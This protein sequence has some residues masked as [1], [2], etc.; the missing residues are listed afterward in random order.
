[1][2]EPVVCSAKGCQATAVY[3]VV[4]NNP[5]IHT[6]ER[7]KIWTACEEHRRSLSDFLDV[8]GF[9]RRVDRL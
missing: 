8:R 5:K 7:E 2:S 1:M 4:W 3:A 9:L 6:P